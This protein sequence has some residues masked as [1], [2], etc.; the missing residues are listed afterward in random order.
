MVNIV[1]ESNLFL[2]LSE[3]HHDAFEHVA[4]QV[5]MGCTL[6]RSKREL[7]SYFGCCGSVQWHHSS[8]VSWTIDC[9]TQTGALD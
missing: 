3:L 7:F 6:R 5:C 2:N 1:L 8:P 4:P 9:T